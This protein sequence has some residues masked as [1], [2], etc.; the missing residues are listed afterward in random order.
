M[1]EWWLPTNASL[2][3]IKERMGRGNNHRIMNDP[4]LWDAGNK[5]SLEQNKLN[6]IQN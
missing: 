6:K 4:K 5:T 2:G 1:A 3:E